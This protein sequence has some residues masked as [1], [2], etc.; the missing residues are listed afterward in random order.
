MIQF[1]HTFLQNGSVYFNKNIVIVLVKLYKMLNFF[2]KYDTINQK[3]KNVGR[4]LFRI[5]PQNII[6]NPHETVEN[7]FND[8]CLVHAIGLVVTNESI[9]DKIKLKF[10]DTVM[11]NQKFIDEIGLEHWIHIVLNKLNDNSGNVKKT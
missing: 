7:L 3:I 1:Y 4:T 5:Y 8:N 11:I 10:K 6:I 9:M 2:C